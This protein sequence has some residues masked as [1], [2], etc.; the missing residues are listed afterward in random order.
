MSKIN[1]VK[2]KDKKSFDKN[3]SKSNVLAVHEPFGIII[4]KDDQEVTP[5]SSK[6]SHSNTVDASLDQISTGLAI[7]IAHDYKE[8][9]AYLKSANVTVTDSFEMTKTFFVEVPDFIPFDSF[10][11]SIMSTGL[12]ISVEP[13]YIMPMEAN[14]E[15]TYTGH[16]HLPNMKC[17]EAWSILPAGV[18]KEVAV[19]DIAC[20]TNHEDL[21]GTISST[22]WNCVTDGPDVNPISEYE[23]HGTACSGV[24]CA[25]TGNDIGCKSISNNH[26]KVQFLHIGYNSSSTGG[27]QTSD[28]IITRAVN[29]AIA[30]PNCVAMSMS[31]SS[32]GSGYPLFSNALNMARTTARN[33][34]GIPLFASSGNS[35]QS[36]FV[37]IPAAYPSVMAVGASTSSDTKA[38]FSNFGPKLF[39]AAPGTSLYTVDRTGAAGYGPESY[40]GFSGTSAS[41]PAMAAVAGCVLVKNPDLTEM[42]VRDIL[43]NS[44]RKVGGYVY[45]EGKSPE[46]GWGI[47]DMYAAVSLA[48]G[49]DPGEPTPGPT[50]NVYGT[51]SSPASVEQG[52][53]TNI[54]YTIIIDKV[55]T[56][57]KSIDVNIAFKKSDGSSLNFYT[58]NVTIP[59]GQ[60][61]KS[62]NI[63]YTIPN[64]IT[65]VCQFVMTVDPNNFLQETNENDNV[66]LTSINVTQ[67][68]TPG[69]GVDGEIKIN[70]YEWLDATRVRIRY[71]FTNRGTVNITSWKAL[72]G[73][74]GRPQT[75]W[76]RTDVIAP[77]RSVVLGSVFPSNLYGTMPNTFKIEVTQVNGAPD[78]NI[79]NNVATIFVQK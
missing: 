34:K 43:K 21:A 54:T 2:F 18:V 1:S 27:F 44:C 24:I 23:K 39:A 51:I 15:M 22:S 48:G 10:Y 49:T 61:S 4:F 6:V 57:D 65:G 74:E 5:D 79:S 29:K 38:A 40:K 55:L 42:Q 75:T 46:L 16:W 56:Q 13:D 62:M 26:L 8:G 35:Y 53:V 78:S 9:M 71:T 20:E 25:N 32:L 59:A 17:Q 12:F 77:G 33:G 41:C 30:N 67:A 52:Q 72:A 73:F 31:W 66:A 37:N 58:G 68:P 60:T 14:A 69:Q 11:G 28:T 3:K 47:I 70:S 76:N 63:P 64:T 19:L 50:Y 45:T 7:L 36:D